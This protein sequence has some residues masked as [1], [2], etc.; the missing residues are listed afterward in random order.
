[1][2][3]LFLINSEKLNLKGSFFPRNIKADIAASKLKVLAQTPN[4]IK[5]LEDIE[6]HFESEQSIPISLLLLKIL[7][8]LMCDDGFYV[9]GRL[10]RSLIEQI[11]GIDDSFERF[12]QCDCHSFLICLLNAIKDEIVGAERELHNKPKTKR[13]I[14][15]QDDSILKNPMDM[16]DGKLCNLFEYL[17][18]GHTEFSEDQLFSSLLIPIPKDRE[19][20]QWSVEDGLWLMTGVEKFNGEL[21]PCTKCENTVNHRK[22]NKQR[23]IEKHFLP[24]KCAK[25]KICK[26]VLVRNT[27][28]Q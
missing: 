17:P 27:C 28:K 15:Q 6:D 20:V 16:F 8:N 19:S 26:I 2:N 12:R 11:H 14:Y 13:S 21:L 23:S 25:M 22:Y 7:V 9:D 1:M 4:F 3:G 5:N 24:V 18:C 10:I